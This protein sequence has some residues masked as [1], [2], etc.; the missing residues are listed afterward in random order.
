M[1]ILLIF[2]SAQPVYGVILVTAALI[3]LFAYPLLA[4]HGLRHIPG[5]P[6]AKLSNVWLSWLSR[7]S[8]INTILHEQHKKYG[9]V[10]RIAPNHVSIADPA[11]LH[12]IY[13]HGSQA[14]KSDFYQAFVQFGG[15]PS[16][17]STRSKEEHARKRKF[18]AH[19]LSMRSVME[20]EPTIA[21]YQRML[22]EHWDRICS[23][24]KKTSRGTVGTQSWYSKDGRAWLD[25]MHW[26]NF[27]AFDIIGDLVFG[28]GFGMVANGSDVVKIAKSQTAALESF[29]SDK[30]D[31]DTDEIPAVKV[32][33]ERGD[34]VATSAFSPAWFRPFLR[35]FPATNKGRRAMELFGNLAVTAIARRLLT[36]PDKV[37]LLSKMVEIKDD[38][39]RT[40]DGR[41]LA[42][43]A[44]TLLIAGSDTTSNSMCAII[45]YLAKYQDIQSILQRE[46]DDV[47]GSP[48]ASEVY[49]DHDK[50][51]DRIKNLPFLE[52]VINEGLRLQS[53]VGGDKVAML[54]AFAPFQ[55]GS[56]ACL[57]RNLA[58]MEMT[59]LLATLLHRYHF[60]LENPAQVLAIYEAIIRKPLECIVGVRRREEVEA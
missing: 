29:D 2:D 28:S 7:T 50:V 35:F 37:D 6:L 18:V 22:V 27:V 45:F 58:N 25:I 41:E 19:A 39:G 11:A 51:Y 4:S 26:L 40:M 30:H 24:A 23:D 44:T 16:V 42:A 13:G 49:D 36:S 57:G 5:P 8:R 43:E 31:L 20:Y 48:S 21:Q 47:L 17:F 54:K 15:T 46:L 12:A 10:V 56:R 59:M 53:T 14:L 33:L 3:A 55:I 9:K 38:G 34:H 52:A 32:V 1:S 60:D